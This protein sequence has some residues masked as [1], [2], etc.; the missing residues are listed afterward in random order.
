MEINSVQNE[1]VRQWDKLKLKKYRD[2]TGCFIIQEKH[3]IKEA[4]EAGLLETLIVRK[5]AVNEFSREAVTVSDAVMKKLSSNVSLNDFIAICR[6]PENQAERE[7]R[8]IVLEKV[9]D[10]GNLGTIIRTAYSFGYDALYLSTD[11][12]D[13]FNE[14]CIQSSQGAIF[15]LPIIRMKMEDIR[16]KMKKEGLTVAVTC[17]RGAS[18]LQDIEIPQRFALVFGNEGRG[19][20]AETI[21]AGDIRVKIE[22]DQF[23][24]LNVAVAAA[25][26]AY[27]FRYGR[28]KS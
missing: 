6:K 1:K 25:I 7:D 18:M 16:K 20:T 26:C 4:L 9:Q 14:K 15:R 10:P 27:Q 21:K 12:C 5:G 2:E 22:M 28:K 24:S 17:L 8:I 19:L 13:E 3:L 11:C 23:E